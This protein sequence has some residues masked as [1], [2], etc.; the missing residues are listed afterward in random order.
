MSLTTIILLVL[1][2]YL[3]LTLLLGLRGTRA[4]SGAA[5][6]YF[7]AGR[8]IGPLVMFFTLVATNFSAFFFLGFAG[9]AYHVGYAFY[10]VMSFGTAL[11]AVTL[12]LVGDRAWRL[13]K[14]TGAISPAELIGGRLNSRALRLLVLAVMLIFTLPYL[15]LQ[16]IGAGLLLERLTGIPYFYGAAGLTVIIVMYV[17]VGGMRSVA[18]TDVLQGALMFALIIVAVVVIAQEFGGIGP[19]NEAVFANRPQM[20][21]AFGADGSLGI[22][23]WAALMLLWPLAV[24]MFPHMFM[25]FFTMRSARSMHLAAVSYPLVTALLFL[26]PVMIGVWGGEIFPDLVGKEADSILPMMVT[27]FSSNWLS[28]LVMVGALAAFM[29]TMDSQLL[30][31]STMLTRDVY[32]EHVR[33]GAG[34]NEQVFVGRV[35][36]PILAALGL[37][38]AVLEP[39]GIFDIVTAAFSGLAALFP[40][41]VAAM[42]APW[43]RPGWCIASILAG[44]FI[45]V[46]HA[47]HL[48]PDALLFGSEP[49]AGIVIVGGLICLVGALQGRQSK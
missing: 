33:P 7:L 31:M 44:E 13:G 14:S 3:L 20:F 19:A 12:Y 37:L 4:G 46:G 45:V 10:G 16:P 34:M 39:A 24:P 25:R 38:I 47:T 26:M 1:G 15:A 9:K 30:A 48:L 29:S 23:R 28:A 11:V 32:I 41:A 5:D 8:S 6:E 21:D 27:Q 35:L 2:F 18:W 22:E 42:Y 43:I 40:A 49:I 36:V 17:Y